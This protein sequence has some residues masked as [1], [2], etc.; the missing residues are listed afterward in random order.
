MGKTIKI[1]GMGKNPAIE[2]INSLNAVNSRLA[3]A[4]RLEKEVFQTSQ[5]EARKRIEKRK[6]IISDFSINF[7]QKS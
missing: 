4:A 2:K 3:A 7:E 6:Q 1:G 5:E